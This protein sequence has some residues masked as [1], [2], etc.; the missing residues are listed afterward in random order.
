MTVLRLKTTLVAAVL[1]AAATVA[2]AAPKDTYAAHC[3]ACHASG[4]A[5]APKIGDAA[6]W[7]RR[8]Q[9]AGQAGLMESALKGRGAMPARGGNAGLSDDEVRGAVLF[10][11][12]AP[13]MPPAVAAAKAAEAQVRV[14]A[15]GRSTYDTACA[16]CHKTGVLNSP[17]LDDGA[18]WAPRL[19]VGAAQLQA[20]AINGKGGMPPKGANPNLSDDEVRA[21]TDYMIALVRPRIA[22]AGKPAPPAARSTP[23]APAAA[24]TTASI[25]S[26]AAADSGRG[27]TVYQVSCSACHAAGVAGA[28]KTGD[29]G[30]WSARLNA[31]TASLVASAIKGKGAMPPKGGNAGLADADVRAAVEFMVAQSR[32]T[33]PAA[34][35]SKGAPASAA[36][37]PAAGAPTPAPAAPTAAAAPVAPVASGAIDEVNAFNR[38][39]RAP[40][41]RN[42][43]PAQ[44]GIHDPTNDG[45][46]SLQAPL[47]AY[48]ALPRSASGNQVDW[49][50]ALADKRISPRAD[51]LDPKAEL[52]VMD[53]NIVREVKGSMPD[54]VY[55]HKQHTEWLDCSNCHPAIFLPQKG[56]NQISMAA[57]L[58]GQ[59]CGVCHGRVAFPVSE[60]RMCHSRKKS[61]AVAQGGE[62][63]Q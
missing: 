20:S 39:L 18:A 51:R 32:G 60:C 22:A 6:E 37:P 55:P 34:A 9:R 15:T 33:A 59:S 52:P 35:P 41:K 23:S 48:A 54:V 10:M 61:A 62:V 1:A 25:A 50:K 26:A 11:T 31:G 43:P 36:A 28:P 53:L 13:A 56:A 7:N 2:P 45:T 47:E 21:A 14:A 19:A 30:A 46:H 4:V 40:G 27:R 38:L 58:L 16:P 12:G 5:N 8:A 24:S 49:V 42:L 57:I 44:D 17:R 3:A 63:R 29:A